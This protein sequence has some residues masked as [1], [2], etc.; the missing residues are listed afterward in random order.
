[1]TPFRA[2]PQIPAAALLILLLGAS[3]A[4]AQSPQPP[5]GEP[6][7]VGGGISAP[8]KLSGASPVYTELARRSRVTGTVILE[9]IIDEQGNVTNV[10]VLKGLPMGLDQ[11][12]VEAVQTWKFKPA[13][14]EGKPVKVY[15]TLTV[16]FQVDQDPPPPPRL[17]SFLNKNPELAEHMKAGRYTEAAQLLDRVAI[18]WA[19]GPEVPLARCYMLLKQGQ[20]EAAWNIAR[21]YK[22]PDPYEMLYLVG[23]FA[24]QQA[25][26]SGVLGPAGRTALIDLGIQAEDMALQSRTDG[27]EAM[28]VKTMLLFDKMQLATTPEEREALNRQAMELRQRTMDLYAKSRRPAGTPPN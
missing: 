3:A 5:A 16:N 21:N 11:S 20:V 24:R 26:Q 6:Y 4:P 19:N 13:M 25:I 1:M 14:L 23:A 12:A 2:T 7:R 10:R 22:G 17:Q 9:A 8:Q 15:Y 28:V 27:L 18:D